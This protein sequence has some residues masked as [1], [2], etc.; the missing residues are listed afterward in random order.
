MKIK[1]EKI[2]TAWDKFLPD[3]ETKER[4]FVNIQKKQQQQLT[5]KLTKE[6][7]KVSYTISTRAPNEKLAPRD[8][9]IK[10]AESIK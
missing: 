5:E 3:N 6:Y 2:I 1:N 10:M 4:M 7:G 9:I 8:E